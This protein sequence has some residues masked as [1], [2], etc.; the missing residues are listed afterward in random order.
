MSI[1]QKHDY[2][3]RASYIGMVPGSANPYR[4]ICQVVRNGPGYEVVPIPKTDRTRRKYTP[5][6][7]TIEIELSNG[8]SVW[9]GSVVYEEHN[10]TRK[11]AGGRDDTWDSDYFLF[12]VSDA[13]QH[14]SI[15]RPNTAI[16]ITENESDNSVAIEIKENVSGVIWNFL[17]N[18]VFCAVDLS[19]L[20]DFLSRFRDMHFGHLVDI[21]RTGD[22]GKAQTR[23]VA[24]VDFNAFDY[25]GWTLLQYAAYCGH[26]E[27]VKWLIDDAGAGT[28]VS[29]NPEWRPILCAAKNNHID[30]IEFLISRGVSVANGRSSDTSVP[31]SLLEGRHTNSL[32]RICGDRGPI[33]KETKTT[34][35]V[36][37]VTPLVG[38]FQLP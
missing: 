5:S 36:R 6:F 38:M 21:C 14:N 1:D 20:E 26:L 2:A 23:H 37:D 22:I 35:G 29:A 28:D 8:E 13:L 15:D 9:A 16:K 11:K 17:K 32:R 19:E 33:A 18:A 25:N 34:H 31:S 10:V 24:E 30:I 12:K 7:D 3:S 4:C 27:I